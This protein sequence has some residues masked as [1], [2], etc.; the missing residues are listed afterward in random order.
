MKLY[1]CKKRKNYVVLDYDNNRN[2]VAKFKDGTLAKQYVRKEQAK[3]LQLEHNKIIAKGKRFKF[4][5][6]YK[7]FAEYWVGLGKDPSVRMSYKSV[8][9]YLSH[10][11]NYIGP[12]FED[13]YL[14][15]I[16]EQ[17]YIQ[18]LVKVRAKGGT[19]KICE[20]LTT[21]IKK[22][23]RKCIAQGKILGHP[24]L[25]FKCPDCQ[26]IQP[27][28]DEERYRIETRAITK[29]EVIKLYDYL[30]L[31]KDNSDYDATRYALVAMFSHLGL[32]RSEMLALRK[33]NVFLDDKRPHI[34][35]SAT[36][37]YE[38]GLR[39]RVK[40]KGS[41]RPIY[42]TTKQYMFFKWWMSYLDEKS[43]YNQYLLPSVNSS[44]SGPISHKAMMKYLWTALSEVGL[45]EIQLSPKGDWVKVID[46][47]FKGCITKTF[48]HFVA[49]SLVSKMK[50][51]GLDKNYVMQRVG[52][53]RWQTTESIYG[54]K[55]VDEDY[56]NTIA[57]TAKALDY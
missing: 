48:R 15:E 18:F 45:A 25:A 22:F 17:E 12:L 57:N 13:L 21:K 55:I 9:G 8:Q 27:N 40:N 24:I 28:T 33:C 35:V 43:P 6:E 44:G 14:D 23:L 46:S 38:E 42:L 3:Q 20:D 54:N 16:T 19:Y 4:K 31:K 53:T 32:R 47:P 56:E 29:A 10:Y 26:E 49:S 5:E 39:H 37:D 7:S 1:I 52:H 51:L 30:F 11:H 2:Q 50:H 41:K 34:K 36:F